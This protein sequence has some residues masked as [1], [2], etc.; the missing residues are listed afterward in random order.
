MFF[1]RH[2]GVGE[3]N[4]MVAKYTHYD[5]LHGIFGWP[6]KPRY[7]KNKTY[8]DQKMVPKVSGHNF[9]PVRYAFFYLLFPEPRRSSYAH[10]YLLFPI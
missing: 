6:S 2:L 9:C 10:S 4:L 7:K 8:L 5:S 3:K 1:L